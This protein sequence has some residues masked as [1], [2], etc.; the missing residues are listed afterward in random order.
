MAK[1][2]D[3]LAEL[4]AQMEALQ[5]ENQSLKANKTLHVALKVT[6]KGGVSAYGLQR[7]PVTLYKEQWL[8][9]LDAKDAILA[10]IEENKA[11]LTVKTAAKAPEAMEAPEPEAA[12]EPGEAA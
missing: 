3:E 9:L 12:S 11:R 8:R 10:F 2:A 5:A 6:D 7:F 1:R 4:R